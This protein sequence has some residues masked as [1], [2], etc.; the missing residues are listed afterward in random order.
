MNVKTVL[1]FTPLAAIALTATNCHSNINSPAGGSHGDHINKILDAV[2]AREKNITS[3]GTAPVS[4]KGKTITIWKNGT[5][6]F[7]PEVYSF[8]KG[9]INTLSNDIPDGYGNLIEYKKTGANTAKI[10][11]EEWESAYSYY[12]VFTSP[13]GGTAIG[14]GWIE[15]DEWENTGLSF[16]L[17]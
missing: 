5:P 7:S 10:E 11:V 1:T 3:G 9:N 13:T 4:M 14:K 17:K 15:G 8:R 2:P 6:S 12:L 16:T